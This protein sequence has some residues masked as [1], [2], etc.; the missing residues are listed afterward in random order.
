MTEGST[1]L[2]IRPIKT[3]EEKDVQNLVRS[4]L[5]STLGWQLATRV[6]WYNPVY[7]ASLVVVLAVLQLCGGWMVTLAGLTI[8]PLLSYW[9]L[10]LVVSKDLSKTIM[11][12]LADIRNNYVRPRRNNLWVAVFMGRIIGCVAVEEAPRARDVTVLRSMSVDA[13][14]QGLGVGKRLLEVLLAFCEE[15]GYREVKLG[16]TEFQLAA[17]GLYERFGFERSGGMAVPLPLGKRLQV[18]DYRLALPRYN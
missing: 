18:W 14:Y 11:H 13:S 15:H 3:G 8:L 10:Y 6:L 4:N 17:Q 12:K 1:G 16:T 2:V 5:W 7:M 9:G